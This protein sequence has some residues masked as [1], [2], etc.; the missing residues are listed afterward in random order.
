L[1][2][3]LGNQG[4]YTDAIPIFEILMELYRQ[5]I[6]A[7][8]PTM[9]IVGGM[10]GDHVQQR[11]Q[12]ESQLTENLAI[13]CQGAAQNLSRAGQQDQAEALYREALALHE[14]ASGQNLHQ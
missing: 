4:R 8:P 2:V 12:L 6:V 11:Q 10:A 13:V 3:F 5:L 14:N 9:V 1:V 7:V